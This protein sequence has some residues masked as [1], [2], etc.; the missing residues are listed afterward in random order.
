MSYFTEHYPRLSY[1][2]RSGGTD[3]DGFRP[4]QLGAIHSVGGHFATKRRPAIVV[5]PTGTGKTGVLT[6]LPFMLRA[7]RVLVIVPS[8]LLRDQMFKEFVRFPLL[9]RIGALPGLDTVPN[10][11]VK[12]L[13]KRVSDPAGWEELRACEVVV[14]IPSSASPGHAGVA[15][16]PRDLFDLVLVDEAHHEAA[17]T[18]R[19]LTTAFDAKVVLC[20]ATPFRRDAREVR[21]T[22]VF[23]YPLRLARD[24]GSFSNI[25]FIPVTGGD[26]KAVARRVRDALRSDQAAGLRHHA[27]IR[28]DLRKRA[29]EL[30]ELYRAET[31]L[32]LEVVHG[33]MA[34]RTARQVL[35]QMVAD[36]LDG[37]IAV[38]MMGEGID[39]PTLKVAGL[40]APYKSI[41]ATLQFL[42]RL[43]RTTLTVGTAKLI[44]V[45]SD[46]QVEAEKL[47]AEDAVWSEL[48]PRLLA[49]RIDAEV[50][51]KRQIDTFEA[52]DD[53][54]EGEGPVSL[55]A[56]TPYFHVKVFRV[57]DLDLEATIKPL[58]GEQL[59]TSVYSAELS[60][61]VL[62]TVRHAKPRFV[63]DS[64]L[65]D[66][67]HGLHV[68]VALPGKGLL[69]ICT[70]SRT[71]KTYKLLADQVA[72][73]FDPVPFFQVKRAL[74]DLTKPRFISV[75][76][77]NS[78][79]GTSTES[80]RMLS[81]KSAEQ[82]IRVGDERIFGLGHAFG[83]DPAT[84]LGVSTLSKVWSHQVKRIPDL[85]EWCASLGERLLNESAYMVNDRLDVLGVPVKATTC[86]RD[87]F[88]VEWN[89]ATWDEG[90]KLAVNGITIGLLSALDPVVVDAT[91]DYVEF[92]L[93]AA[94]GADLVLRYSPTAKNQ[95]FFVSTG[96]AA[97]GATVEVDGEV[98]ALTAY[99]NAT[100]PRFHAVA[101]GFLE[102]GQWL[103][104]RTGTTLTFPA[105]RIVAWD[106]KGVDI[107]KESK[108]SATTGLINIQAR[109]EAEVSISAVP[110]LFNDD[111]AGE[112]ADI[113]VIDTDGVAVTLTLY[114]CKF[115]SEDLPGARVA[116]LYEVC[117]QGLKSA[118]RRRKED[119]VEHLR[120]RF[121]GGRPVRGDVTELDRLAALALTWRFKVV[122]VQPGVSQAG[123]TPQMTEIVAAT[124]V[125]LQGQGFEP[126]VL[127]C[128]P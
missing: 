117:G 21:G 74:R 99:L 3:D 16:P 10:P 30:L 75:G 45:P 2:I 13:Q 126:L 119:I 48:V 1:P 85:V 18:W 15:P 107:R 5:M 39:L 127:V 52:D 25:E 102:A 9:R 78:L 84:T 50:E 111:G 56:L 83:V 82:G 49:E 72:D 62:V 42:G 66:R 63:R 124:D 113:V 121:G 87:I 128:S 92:K 94:T 104:P 11:R 57:T 6:A 71:E 54:P 115:S 55:Y 96:P 70:S 77:R 23:D 43:T 93:E 27:L 20:S 109:V 64:D 31:D 60:T 69:F 37:I 81:G 53:D 101:G 40:H 32:R 17:E 12:V 106:W 91:D 80:Y 103:A 100:P 97:E 123:L 67:E 108:P 58:P 59:V 73:G 105:D 19:A 8:R 14:S 79:S 34:G 33:A 114:H 46:I 38:N 7:T 22:I 118:R 35:D 28:T 24:D 76:M 26:D 122:L 4:A 89:E 36:E 98:F 47:Y 120:R 88:A 29:D 116:D 110:F 44:A 51:L 95:E 61:R 41:A 125:Y 86:R 68:F 90:A 65:T 112:L